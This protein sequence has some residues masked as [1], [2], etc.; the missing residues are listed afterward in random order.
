MNVRVDTTGVSVYSQD[1]F[2]FQRRNMSQHEDSPAAYHMVLIPV[3][4]MVK[5]SISKAELVLVFRR[6]RI[7]Y[8]Y[9]HIITV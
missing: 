2:V 9:D 1:F 5:K 4:S 7:S 3:F 6:N 8:L